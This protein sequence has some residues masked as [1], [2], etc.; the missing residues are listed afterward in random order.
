[1]TIAAA[2]LDFY[3]DSKHELMSKIAMPAAIARAQTTVLTADQHAALP[4]TD[5]GLIVLT[6]RAA[7]MRRYPVNDPGNAWLSAQY[8]QATHEKLAWPARFIAAKFIKTACDAYGVPN[9]KMVAA[10][11]AR[12]G[13]DEAT[14]NTFV[15]GSETGWMLRKLAERE[16]IEKQ[17]QA[18]EIE[19]FVNLPNEHWGLVVRSEDGTIL[20][21][22]AMPT[23]EYVK[24]AAEYFDKYAMDLS[25]PHRHQFARNVQARAAELEVDVS[26][27]DLLEKWA[28]PGWNR[29]VLAHIEQRKSLLPRNQDARS[30]LDKL[31]ASLGETSPE[32]AAAALQA[33]D[34][35]TGLSRYYDRGLSDPYASTMGKVAEGWSDEVDGMTITEADLRKEAVQKKIAGYMGSSFASQFA[36]NPVEIYESLPAPE[37]ALIKQVISGEA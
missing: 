10:Y 3:D 18:A 29:H 35:A 9:S 4:D 24:V 36:A 8:F 5:F 23:A 11:A 28:S 12:V 30:V 19:A 13:D 37:K 2:V 22:Y 27:H 15:E 17:A 21:K 1:M 6:K 34:A 7:V 25:P 14:S 31:A 16:F 33:I 26:G 32:D 20:R